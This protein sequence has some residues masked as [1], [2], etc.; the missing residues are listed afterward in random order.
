MRLGH[1]DEQWAGGDVQW[2]GGDVQWRCENSPG[3]S[4]HPLGLDL[5]LDLVLY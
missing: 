1:K 5:D 3:Q 4:S 2:A